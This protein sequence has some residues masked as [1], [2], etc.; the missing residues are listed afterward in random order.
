MK[1]FIPGREWQSSDIEVISVR[2]DAQLCRQRDV[3]VIVVDAAAEGRVHLD[4]AQD[5][6]QRRRFD[7]QRRSRATKFQLAF[8][9]SIFAN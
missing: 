3:I 2:R 5:V 9:G 1:I 6:L 8:A 7:A 4:V